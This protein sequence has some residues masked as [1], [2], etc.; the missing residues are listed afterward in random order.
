MRPLL[1][2]GG[3]CFPLKNRRSEDGRAFHG[4]RRTAATLIARSAGVPGR[5]TSTPADHEAGIAFWGELGNQKQNSDSL[6]LISRAMLLCRSQL[7][8]DSNNLEMMCYEGEGVFELV[9]ES[10]EGLWRR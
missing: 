1:I 6:R 8:S 9:V 5:R 7:L 4:C 2:I 10:R 3:Y